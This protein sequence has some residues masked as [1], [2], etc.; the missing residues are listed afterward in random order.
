MS[1]DCDRPLD[2]IDLAFILCRRIYTENDCAARYHDGRMYSL[3]L[4]P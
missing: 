4:Q 2:C 1:G 3:E